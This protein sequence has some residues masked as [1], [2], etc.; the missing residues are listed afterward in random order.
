MA[1]LGFPT[2]GE[3]TANTVVTPDL[4]EKTIQLLEDPEQRV[5]VDLNVILVISR[6][7]SFLSGFH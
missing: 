6:L 1:V 5:R 2:N 7:A 3:S 4:I